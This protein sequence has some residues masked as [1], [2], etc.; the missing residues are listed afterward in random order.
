MTALMW[1]QNKPD[2]AKSPLAK[3]LGRL[4]TDRD[5]VQAMVESSL[6]QIKK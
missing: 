5:Q 3:F 1:S 4:P 2:G 6:G